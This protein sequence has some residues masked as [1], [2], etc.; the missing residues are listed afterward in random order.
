MGAKARCAS[1]V[2]QQEGVLKEEHKPKN[3]ENR[4]I[5]RS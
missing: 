5:I 3:N 4:Y 2:H 1:V